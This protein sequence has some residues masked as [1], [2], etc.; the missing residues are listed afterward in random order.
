MDRRHALAALAVGPWLPALQ[1]GDPPPGEA[2]RHTFDRFET[3]PNI[4]INEFAFAEAPWR[5]ELIDPP[6]AFDRGHLTVSDRPGFGIRLNDALVR[7]LA[8]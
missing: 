5:A 4:E 3:L 2:S 6:E 1:R 7:R 8:P